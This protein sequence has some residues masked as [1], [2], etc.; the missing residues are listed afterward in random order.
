MDRAQ[1]RRGPHLKLCSSCAV[2]AVYQRRW[3]AGRPDYTATYNASRRLPPRSPIDCPGCG[4][5]FIPLRSYSRYCCAMCSIQARTYGP[6]PTAEGRAAHHA[7]HAAG[8]RGVLLA[9]V[10]GRPAN[11]KDLTS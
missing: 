4:L 10:V 5:R 11:E 7:S 6:F 9:R 2:P 1:P 3:L 8:G